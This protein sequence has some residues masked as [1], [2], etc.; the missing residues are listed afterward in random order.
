MIFHHN[1]SCWDQLQLE[2][3]S[4]ADIDPHDKKHCLPLKQ[5]QLLAYQYE[6]WYLTPVAW[7]EDLIP[8]PVNSYKFSG[9]LLIHQHRKFM[10]VHV[11]DVLYKLIVFIYIY[12]CVCVCLFKH[13]VIV[14]KQILYSI[15][16]ECSEYHTQ[17][18]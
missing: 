5:V 6:M 7:H 8:F 11:C 12:M 3:N 1:L 9:V 16:Q 10:Y 4:L 15:Q 17:K 13:I 18:Q 14:Y 2:S